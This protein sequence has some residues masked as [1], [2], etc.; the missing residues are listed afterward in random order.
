MRLP[1]KVAMGTHYSQ[2]SGGCPNSGRWCNK[3][4]NKGRQ[5]FVRKGSIFTEGLKS[6][7]PYGSLT[8]SMFLC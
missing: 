5:I 8:A 4:R 1:G 3:L 2:A 6:T 7:H